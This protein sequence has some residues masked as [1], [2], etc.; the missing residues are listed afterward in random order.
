[1]SVHPNKVLVR[2]IFEEMWNRGDPAAAGEIFSRP[3][4]VEQ[5]MREFLTAFPDLEHIIEDEIAEVDQVVVRFSAHGTHKGPWREYAPSGKRIHYSGV[6]IA[7]IEN[8]MVV[9][10]HTWWD[11]QELI[12]QIQE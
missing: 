7:R 2:R 3:E 11:R 12:E 5:F 1:M 6:T 10:H 4:G 8:G 9:E